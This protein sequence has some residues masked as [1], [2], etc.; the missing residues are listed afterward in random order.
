MK[1]P[2]FL[3]IVMLSAV[4]HA[5]PVHKYVDKDGRVHYTDRPPEGAPSTEIRIERPH[6]PTP[7]SEPW[8]MV[9]PEMNRSRMTP[10]QIRENCEN[11]WARYREIKAALDRN[12]NAVVYEARKRMTP[13]NLEEMAQEIRDWGCQ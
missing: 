5:V 13:D 6:A 11:W 3:F 4:A 9:G 2:L 1:T 10:S 8:H 7:R 12:P